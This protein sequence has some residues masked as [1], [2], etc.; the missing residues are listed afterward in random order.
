MDSITILAGVH[1]LRSWKE[2]DIKAIEQIAFNYW[3]S[4]RLTFKILKVTADAISIGITQAKVNQPGK[5]YEQKELI[6]LVHRLFDKYFRNHKIHVHASPYSESPALAVNP[7][8]IKKKMEEYGVKLKDM[9]K[10]TGLNNTQLSPL[11]TG[12]KPLSDA[13][14]AMFYFYF[15]SKEIKDNL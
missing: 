2:D 7:D 15:R 1:L 13:M 9:A 11:I 5:Q 6:D 3:Q 10:E 14:K 4:D 12:S 8:W